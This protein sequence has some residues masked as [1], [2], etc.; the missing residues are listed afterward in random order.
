MSCY[1]T[2]MIGA[3]LLG[4]T[5][6]SMFYSKE[7]RSN[8]LVNRL[9]PQQLA[10]YNSIVKERSRIYLEGNI[11]G[12]VLALIYFFN[13]GK[14]EKKTNICAFVLIAMTTSYY[15]Y[16]LKP[17]SDYIIR[18][19]SDSIQVEAWLLKYK[20]MKRRYHIGY[21]LGG[22]GYLILSYGLYSLQK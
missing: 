15:Y 21:L 4:G 20:T 18:H 11:L 9:N 5:L 3:S 1:I 2:C 7:P 8:V 6:S 14:F 12:L 16:T 13:S 10:I 22:L 19:L 17:K